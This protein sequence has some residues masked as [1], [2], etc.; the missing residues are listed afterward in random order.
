MKR[1]ISWCAVALALQVAPS[2]MAQEETPSSDLTS[3]SLEDL[4]NVTVTASRFE[5]SELEAPATTSVLTSKE[6]RDSGAR[7][8]PD[9]LALVPGVTVIRSAPGHWT[10]SIRG[11]NGLQANNVVVLVDG[12]RVNQSWDGE[13]DWGALPLQPDAIERIEVVRGPV[14]VL[15]GAN[16]YTGVINL[17]T[18]DPRHPRTAASASAGSD[19]NGR[20]GIA[21]SAMT[22][23]AGEVWSMQL[24]LAADVDNRSDFQG[25]SA[26]FGEESYHR[27]GV[28][29]V[30]RWDFST[31][32]SLVL[33]TAASYMEGADFSNVIPYP[34]MRRGVFADGSATLTVGNIFGDGDVFTFRGTFL[35]SRTYD[36]GHDDDPTVFR[37]GAV[38]DMEAGGE[39]SYRTVEFFRNRLLLGGNLDFINVDNRWLT[40]G[41]S[42]E[43]VRQ[44]GIYLSDEIN[45]RPVLLTAGVR[46]D[47]HP[48]I[49]EGKVSYRGSIA[50]LWDTHVL[51]LSGGSSFR[52]PTFSELGARYEATFAN[53]NRFVVLEGN[54]SLRPPQ[55][56]SAELA[57]QGIIADRLE[58][59][60]SVF[61]NHLSDLIYQDFTPVIGKSYA[62]LGTRDIIGAEIALAWLP[63]TALRVS[64]SYTFQHYINPPE[65]AFNTIGYP[66]AN[67]AHMA[68]LGIAGRLADN[69]LSMGLSALYRSD[70]DYLLRVGIPP[71][72]LV[73]EAGHHVALTPR[74]GWDIVPEQVEIYLAGTI[75]L[76]GDFQESPYIDAARL[77]SELLIGLSAV[78]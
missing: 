53:G 74:I 47:F 51:R 43:T 57:Y 52:T 25:A 30:N 17:I 11:M 14:S 26:R 35:G 72:I 63:L 5:Q 39:V 54:P 66:G 64:A 46:A 22:G 73:H 55:I 44:N 32:A 18:R 27:T 65:N 37:L 45:L 59:M 19:I 28:N 56:I 67:P 24:A 36:H 48:S 38:S 71:R 69:R 77:G 3:W 20:P 75:H 70:T 21:A 58:L 9:L 16:A 49:P 8:I 33:H 78:Q 76:P 7:T 34:S 23:Y 12:V 68:T 1:F 61:Y 31:D 42:N 15:Y 62:N 13:V 41:F 50:Y 29:M 6:I 10:V 60:P 2:A 4:L 40:D